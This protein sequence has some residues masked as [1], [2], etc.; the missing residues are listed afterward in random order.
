MK[1]NCESCV[2][3]DVCGHT[4]IA[5]ELCEKL[6]LYREFQDLQ[7]KNINISVSCNSYLADNKIIRGE[8]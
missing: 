3:K 8:E 4:R 1:L 2:K 5:R 6:S 7:K